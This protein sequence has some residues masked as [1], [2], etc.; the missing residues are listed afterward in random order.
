[1]FNSNLSTLCILLVIGYAV[2]YF[3]GRK[4][5]ENFDGTT[6]NQEAK[7]ETKIEKR[8]PES[9]DSD[10]YEM[11]AIFQNQ[12]S[13]E[14]SKKQISDA[15]TRYPMDWSVQGPG[16]Q[17]YQDNQAKYEQT[18]QN[19]QP[20]QV[21]DE[22]LPDMKSMEEEE[23][24]IL[25][26]YQPESSKGLLEYSVEDVK[27]LL[28]KIYSKRGLIPVIE[29]SKQG[30]NIWEIVELKEKD[31][32]IVWE[33]DT[34]RQKMTQRGEDNID[35]PYNASDMA[36]GLDPFLKPRNAIDGKN[37]YNTFSPELNDV[38]APTSFTPWA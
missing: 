1:M 11:S 7:Q 24:K 13:K 10:Q 31:P 23:Q 28:E 19:T 33:D 20:K 27:T 16:S 22:L 4:Y 9:K 18:N 15:M 8:L 35:I 38:F 5:L 36:A 26:T 2:L 21:T 6:V 34:E 17:Y 12:G 14:A 37:S 32:L 30:Q 25:Q 29:Q 3:G